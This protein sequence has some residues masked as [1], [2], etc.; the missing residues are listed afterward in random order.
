MKKQEP[1]GFADSHLVVTMESGFR[2]K[3]TLQKAGGM[4]G[5]VRFLA[6]SLTDHASLNPAHILTFLFQKSK[7]YF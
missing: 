3:L 6:I 4:M 5:E 2:V 1:L 7:T